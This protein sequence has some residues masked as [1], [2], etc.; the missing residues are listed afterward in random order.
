[1]GLAEILGGGVGKIFKDIVGTFKLDP[2]TK[3][4]IEAELENH[5]FEIAKLEMEY[6]AKVQEAASR[7]IVAEASSA[8][9]LARNSRPFFV[10]MGGILIIANYLL[11]LVTQWTQYP[12]QP[13]ALD[14]WFYATYSFG[15][16]GYTYSA[17]RY[18]QMRKGK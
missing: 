14:E 7:N 9:W 16:G 17:I 4:K 18:D 1:M 12:M 13:I 15:F 5:R 10:F 2:E 11:P 3:A 8:S 6:D